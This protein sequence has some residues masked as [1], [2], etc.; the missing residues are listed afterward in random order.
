M[1][2]QEHSNV[3]L[4]VE[5]PEFLQVS[6]SSAGDGGEEPVSELQLPQRALQTDEGFVW[7]EVERVATHFQAIET[8]NQATLVSI[9]LNLC[10]EA[11]EIV[12][13]VP[14]DVSMNK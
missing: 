12:V 5:D 14:Q 1:F 8:C 11:R 9:L 10:V 6:E 13:Q 3:T 4:Q 7:D 2:L